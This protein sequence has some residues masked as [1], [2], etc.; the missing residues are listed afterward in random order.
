MTALVDFRLSIA[1]ARNLTV[2]YA[3]LRRNWGLGQRGRLTPANEDLLWLP[4]AAIVTSLSSLDA[5]VHAVLDDR[6]PHALRHAP[7]PDALSEA[8]A[9]IIPIK[10]A[11]S[12]REAFPII[13][14]ANVQ[15]ELTKRLREESLAFASYQAPKNILSAYEMIGCPAIFN[16]V[17]AIW[18]GPRTTA[19]DLKRTL[20]NYVKRR[21][22]IAHEGD[23]EAGGGVRHMQPIYASNC[24][25]FIE[26]LVAR[27]NRVV[28]NV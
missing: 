21:N 14:A 2:M 4:R 18:P 8:M 3:E 28:Y 22:Q 1:S 13:S 6:I 24:A 5:Y 26:G 25:D 27:L 11:A 10:S 7:I 9:N 20:A 23:R 16:S 15:L 17:S 19:D 12:F